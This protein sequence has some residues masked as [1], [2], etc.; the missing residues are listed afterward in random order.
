MVRTIPLHQEDFYNEKEAEKELKRLFDICHGCRRCF[1]LCGLFPKLFERLDSPE[2]DGDVEKLTSEDIRAIVPSCTLCDMCYMVKCPYVPPH[3]WAV[4]FPRAILRHRAI[5][6]KKNRSYKGFVE[7]R[8]AHVDQYLPLANACT[9]LSNAVLGCGALRKVAQVATGIDHR[10]DLPEFRKKPLK[11]TW[12]S[13]EPNPR[14][15]AHG[16]EVWFYLTCMTNYYENITAR[17][18]ALVFAHFGVRV[19]GIYPGCC[20]MPLLEQGHLED[21]RAQAES[22]APQLCGLGKIIPLTP[23]CSLMLRSEWPSLCPE[24]PMVREV[25]EGTQDLMPYALDLIQGSPVPVKMAIPP[26]VTVHMAC[27]VRAQNQGNTSHQLL[28]KLSLHTV[29][30]VERCSGHGGMWGYKKEHFEEALAVGKPVITQSAGAKIMTS[31]CP[32]AARHLQQ[33]ARMM[34]VKDL[35]VTHPMVLL[36]QALDPEFFTQ[37]VPPEPEPSFSLGEPAYG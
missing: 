12:V 31:E 30:L 29:G 11:N 35:W 27:H 5:L 6:A 7:K 21:L 32:M 25:A 9:P 28:S 19:H 3:P 16:Q 24:N 26:H 14:G 37:Q 10:A 1:N 4:D 20:G 33:E 23:S 8:L 13:P 2:I 15:Y 17:A 36:A 18:A 34:G 22:V